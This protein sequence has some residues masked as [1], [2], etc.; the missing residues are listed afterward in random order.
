[1]AAA[2]LYV[3]G[4]NETLPMLVTRDEAARR[5]TLSV[6]TVD[7]LAAEGRLE[8]VRVSAGRVAI[9]VASIDRHLDRLNTA[10]QDEPTQNGRRVPK[11]LELLRAQK[12]SR[13]ASSR[14]QRR[15]AA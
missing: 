6:E 5:M 7:R 12:A 9:L 2:S 3:H 4:M 10:P 14:R 11:R 13:S 1:M 15:V 8:K